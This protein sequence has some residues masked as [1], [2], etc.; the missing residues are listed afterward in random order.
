MEAVKSFDII[1]I[2]G[3]DNLIG[4]AFITHIEIP[5]QKDT[6]FR[7]SLVPKIFVPFFFDLLEPLGQHR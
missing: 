1:L 4:L 3:D 6:V 2:K 5:F 7:N